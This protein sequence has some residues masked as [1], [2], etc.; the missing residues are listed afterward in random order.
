M[1]LRQRMRGRD[2]SRLLAA[3][4]GR[5]A[6]VR[7]FTGGAWG[8]PQPPRTT[9]LAGVAPGAVYFVRH[10]ESTS[11]ERGILAGIIDVK[12]T[13]FGEL[14]A[15]AAGRDLAAKGVRV[16]VVFTSHLRRTAYTARAALE[17][18]GQGG[19]ALQHDSRIAERSFGIFAGQNIRL[20]QMALGY[21]TYESLMHGAHAAPPLGEPVASV[22]ARVAS[23]YE[24][25]AVPMA[26]T[27][28][29]VL[30]VSHQYALEP[31]ALYV[32][33]LPPEAYRN[34]NLPNGKALSVDDLRRYMASEACNTAFTLDTCSEEDVSSEEDSRTDDGMVEGQND[35]IEIGRFGAPAGACDTADAAADDSAP[36]MPSGTAP[37]HA[38]GAAPAHATPR[39][40]GGGSST[41]AVLHSMNLV[42]AYILLTQPNYFLFAALAAPLRAAGAAAG[43]PA[44]SWYLFWVAAAFFVL[45]ALEQAVL[46]RA[47]MRRL[48]VRS[49]NTA[50][51]QGQLD[52]LW[53]TVGAGS[54]GSISGAPGGL[55]SEALEPVV[56]AARALATADTAD[57][58]SPT[59]R[60]LDRYAA[61]QLRER[62]AATGGGDRGDGPGVLGAGI[63]YSA[64]SRYFQSTGG[65]LD[66]N[67]PSCK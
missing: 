29:N 15:R 34:V 23:F 58:S 14:Q 13:D 66:L 41:A 47:F 17:A 19:M 62:I 59:M 30:V 11:N 3:T 8:R 57:P 61:Q 26:A 6:A 43:G 55:I 22:Y 51:P 40:S 67:A 5:A 54:G 44:A 52:A 1:G 56:A 21:E 20:L 38:G 64:F 49:H 35:D 37:S 48:L 2:E 24:D 50:V 39:G 18:A 42:D 36:L 12:L 9:S 16:D 46:V 28:K 25:V 27:G 7:S 31:L 53:A 10:G 32:S 63:N 45:P 60:S 33:G 65:N 4:L